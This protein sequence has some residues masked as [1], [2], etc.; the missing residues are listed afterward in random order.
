MRIAAGE[1]NVPQRRPDLFRRNETYNLVRSFPKLDSYAPLMADKK[2]PLFNE[3]PFW[4]H[5]KIGV[6]GR[7]PV[8]GG[9]ANIIRNAQASRTVGH[10]PITITGDGM[11]EHRSVLRTHVL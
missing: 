5:R 10:T 8:K 3:T 4:G 9:A 6:G 2:S 7:Q 11:P 1:T